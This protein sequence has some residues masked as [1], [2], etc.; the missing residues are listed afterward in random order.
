MVRLGTA[1]L[2]ALRGVKGLALGSVGQVSLGL[3]R[4]VCFMIYETSLHGDVWSL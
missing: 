2:E 3:L 1:V 4:L